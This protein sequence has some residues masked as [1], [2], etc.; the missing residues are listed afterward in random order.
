LFELTILIAE[1]EPRRAS[2]RRRTPISP[3]QRTLP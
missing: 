3:E 2:A 1:R